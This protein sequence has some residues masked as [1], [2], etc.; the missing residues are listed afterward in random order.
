VAQNAPT[1]FTQ[2]KGKQTQ[3]LEADQHCVQHWLSYRHLWPG[4]AP[5]GHQIVPVCCPDVG[6]E[7]GGHL[8]LPLLILVTDGVVKSDGCDLKS[9]ALYLLIPWREAGGCTRYPEKA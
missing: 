6:T 9:P 3:P 5:Q 8:F 4:V 7:H 2:G 1:A